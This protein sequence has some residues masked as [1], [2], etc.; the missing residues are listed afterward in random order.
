MNGGELSIAASALEIG[1]SYELQVD[2]PGG[3]TGILSFLYYDTLMI[4]SYAEGS[5]DGSGDGTDLPD[6]IVP[7]PPTDSGSENDSGSRPPKPPAVIL[8][9]NVPEQLPEQPT[10]QLPTLPEPTPEMP[11]LVPLEPALPASHK[12]WR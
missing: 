9:P 12:R 4:I 5:R 7:L 6:V 10:E 8:E 11:P 2:Y 3:Q 1:G